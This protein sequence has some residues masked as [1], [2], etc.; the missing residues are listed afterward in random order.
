MS[1]ELYLRDVVIKGIRVLPKPSIKVY[2]KRNGNIEVK[3]KSDSGIKTVIL[4]NY[5]I[6]YQIGLLS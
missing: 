5:V 4:G 2:P 6:Y 1:S 3:D